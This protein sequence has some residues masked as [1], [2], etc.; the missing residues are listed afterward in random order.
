M[1]LMASTLAL[2]HG[3]RA[4]VVI[5]GTP[6]AADTVALEAAAGAKYLPWTVTIPAAPGRPDPERDARL[7]QIAAMLE[8]VRRRDGRATAFVCRDFA[9]QEPVSDPAALDRQLESSATPSRI[10][11]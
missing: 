3:P 2:W 6:G 7:P 9:C 5:A 8:T 10:I 1:P 4:E 11:V